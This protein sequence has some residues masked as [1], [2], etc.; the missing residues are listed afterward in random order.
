ME[1]KCT[2]AEFAKIM[3]LQLLLCGCCEKRWRF[4]KNKGNKMFGNGH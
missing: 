1:P 2:G 3:P 4:E